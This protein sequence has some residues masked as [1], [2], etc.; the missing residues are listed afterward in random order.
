MNAGMKDMLNVMSRMLHLGL[1]LPEVIEQS[2]W[3]AARA[4][5]QPELGQLSQ[6]AP[7]DITV[8]GVREGN[9]GFV[10]TAGFRMPG[11]LKPECELTVRN[12]R[13]VWDLNGLAARPFADP[14]ADSPQSLRIR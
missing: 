13:I 9:F 6:C 4:I 10:D 7:A 3:K 14:R 5:Q 1:T 11:K 12:G 2:T 8:P